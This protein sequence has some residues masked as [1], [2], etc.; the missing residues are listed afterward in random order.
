ML[1]WILGIGMYPVVFILYFVL[2]NTAKPKKGLVFGVT[3]KKEWLSEEEIKTLTDEY[4]KKMKRNMLIMA[5]LPVFCFLTDYVSIQM[6]IWM[7]WI[8]AVIVA[9][10]LPFVQA[11]KK[12]TQLRKE[13]G[14]QEEAGRRDYVELKAA[15]D[16]R[17]VKFLP[18][19][20]PMLLSAL[21]VLFPYLM[22]CFYGYRISDPDRIKIFIPVLAILAVCTPFFYL[23]AVWLDRRKTDVIST[24][25]SVNINYARAKKNV[26]KNFWL[27]AA[28]CN[29]VYTFVAAIALVF[30]FSFGKVLIWGIVVYSV[31]LAY[32]CFVALKKLEHVEKIYEEKKDISVMTQNDDGWIWGIMYY[33]PK[34]RHTLVE[35]RIGMG[36]TINMATPFGKVMIV[37]CVLAI[38]SVPVLCGWIILEEFVPIRLQIVGEQLQAKQLN[39]DYDIEID[40][41][42][43]LEL[44]E[45]LPSWTKRNGSAMDN[46][47]KGKFYVHNVGPCE[48]FLNPQNAVFMRFTAEDTVYYMSG[49]DDE[50]TLEVYELLQDGIKQ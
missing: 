4:N 24:D 12:V 43:N 11:N 16:V 48:V 34:D 13:K 10:E 38:L 42:Q 22:T 17:K 50:E 3:M 7:L 8:F 25:S 49:V 21:A 30:D 40:T 1:N 29:A 47:D 9:L 33:N 44:I 2:K 19:L 45:E 28:W 20:W 41:I 6:T 15:G 32:L 26:W 14:W 27:Q 36:T 18:F 31:V 23:A 5:V 35:N 37:V 39:M 46:L